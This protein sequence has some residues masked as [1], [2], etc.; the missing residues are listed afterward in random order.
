MEFRDLKKQYEMIEDEIQ[1]GMKTV[2]RDCNFI[3]GRQVDVL[4]GKLAEYVGTKHCITCANGTDA[5]SLAL[6]AWK[7]GE[8]DAVFVPDF[9]F[10]SSGEVVSYAGATPVFVDID[11][12]TFNISVD[13]L[14]NAIQCV[15]EDGYL[16]PKV[17]IAVDLF[18]QPA[19]YPSIR[20]IAEKYDLM[21]LEDGAQGFGGEIEGQK[22][23]SFGNISTTSFFPAKPLGCYGDGGAIFTDNDD[24]EKYLR[25]IRIHGK[26]SCKYDNIRIGMNSRLDTLQAAILLP[27]LKAFE[28]YE[29]EKINQAAAQYTE[30]LKDVVKTPFIKEGFYSSW[31]QYSVLLPE[32]IQREELQQNLKRDDIPTMVYYPKPMHEQKAFLDNYLV[33]DELSNTK[34]ICRRILSLP[35]HP[36]MKSE[37]VEYVAE[38]LK[39]YLCPDTLY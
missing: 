27:K 23:C 11:K 32:N 8:G 37:D 16:T 36:Y 4:E 2:I 6:M 33:F 5:L 19:D 7:I 35:I 24:I 31:A 38:C 34:E 14:E 26:G 10:F 25:S 3:S 12:D 30:I 22:A 29:L 20:K 21:I 17:I 13:S 9:T 28:K 18:G 1:E 39:K 15:I